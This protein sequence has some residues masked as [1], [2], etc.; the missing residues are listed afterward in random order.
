[1]EDILQDV[2]NDHRSI[3][4]GVQLK[5]MDCTQGIKLLGTS[6]KENELKIILADMVNHY[7]MLETIFE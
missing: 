3:Y 6:F 4:F 1:M 5:I 7:F 2:S